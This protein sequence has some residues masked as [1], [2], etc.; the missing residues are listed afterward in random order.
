VCILILSFQV[1]Q[2]LEVCSPFFLFQANSYRKN[3]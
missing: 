2:H 3:L 1:A